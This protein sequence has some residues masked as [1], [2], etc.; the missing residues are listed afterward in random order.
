VSIRLKTL[1]TLALTAGLALSIAGCGKSSSSTTL[2]TER[3]IYT[4]ASD[5]AASGKLTIDICESIIERA[6]ATHEKTATSYASLRSCET[7]EGA[8]RCERGQNDSYR[9]RLLAFIVFKTD[10]P[11]SQPLYAT[12]KGEPGFRAADKTMYLS[13]DETLLFSSHAETLYESNAGNGRKKRAS[14]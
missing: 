9:P 14:R 4:S 3:G 5:C 1:S 12:P 7:A 8:D 11:Y 10:N 13:S 2:K 6:I